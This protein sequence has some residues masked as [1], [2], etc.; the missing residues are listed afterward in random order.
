M[1][2]ID[3]E[4]PLFCSEIREEERNEES[5]TSVT[6][7]VT[8]EWRVPRGSRGFAY[9]ARTLT[10]QRSLGQPLASSLRSSPRIFEQKRDCSQFMSSTRNFACN[11]REQL[12]LYWLDCDEPFWI[13]LVTIIIRKSF[14]LNHSTKFK[15]FQFAF[16]GRYVGFK[17]VWHFPYVRYT[18][19]K[20]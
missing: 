1:S 19:F 4:Q 10:T 6:A 20:I 12:F 8:C 11:V 9:H 7:S 17:R 3:C 14:P 15:G 2:S 16:R 5:K 13:D 18:C